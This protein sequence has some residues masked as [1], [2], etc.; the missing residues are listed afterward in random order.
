VDGLPDREQR[1][2]DHRR[3]DFD[4]TVDAMALTAKEMNASTRRPRRAASLVSVVLC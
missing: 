1:D 2:P 3:V 4:T